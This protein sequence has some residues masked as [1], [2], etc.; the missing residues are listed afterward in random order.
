VAN[1]N[2]LIFAAQR[3]SANPPDLIIQV[4]TTDGSAVFFSAAALTA[5]G[6]AWL[7][8]SPGSGTTPSALTV[9]ARLGSLPAGSYTGQILISTAS[10]STQVTI[11]VILVVTELTCSYAIAPIG[12][13]AQAS[14][15][16]GT[17]ITVTAPTGCTW[18]ATSNASWITI[19][20]GSSGSGNGTVNYT[21]AANTSTSSRTG[22]LTIAGQ[23]FTVTQAGAPALTVSPTTLNF[24][25][26]QGGASPAS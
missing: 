16:T 7:W 14:G 11:P 15:G 4:S 10:G 9:S 6:G 25:A 8:V 23:T 17:V 1:P 21:V 2:S 20:W 19:T 13:A 5:S 3:G 22:T 24:T 26:Q 18:T 12:A